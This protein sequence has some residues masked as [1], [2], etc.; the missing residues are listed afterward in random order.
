[1]SS[2]PESSN[3]DSDSIATKE[4]NEASI[5]TSK[6]SSEGGRPEIA[7]STVARIMGVA[8]QSDLALLEGKVDLMLSKLNAVTVRIEKF[9]TQLGQIPTGSDLE[10]IDVQIGN[11]RSLIREV[12]ASKVGG[13]TGESTPEPKKKK[14]ALEEADTG[15]E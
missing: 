10:R 2:Q 12:L 3:T 14:S 8:T 5:A 1:M 4:K 13:A 15:E 7:A 9:A 11:L 6:G